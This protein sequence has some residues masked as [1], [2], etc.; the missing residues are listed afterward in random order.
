[1]E[2]ARAIGTLVLASGTATLAYFRLGSVDRA[3]E[4]IGLA[5]RELQILDRQNGGLDHPP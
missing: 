3:P 1:M 2:R 5:R 4:Q